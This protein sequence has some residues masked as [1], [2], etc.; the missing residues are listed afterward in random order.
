MAPGLFGPWVFSDNAAWHGDYTLNYNFEA[1]F[2]GAYSSN[3]VAQAQS[4]Y[5]NKDRQEQ[6]KQ[7]GSFR[8]SITLADLHVPRAR[9]GV[10]HTCKR[11]NEPEFV[12]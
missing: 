6:T 5:A 11:A 8:N 4:Q 12:N 1:T 2:Y 9:M 3:H 10:H 7:G